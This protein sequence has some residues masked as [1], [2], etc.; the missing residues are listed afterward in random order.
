MSRIRS[1]WNALLGKESIL[2][3]FVATLCLALGLVIVYGSVRTVWEL[4][5]TAQTIP[6]IVRTPPVLWTPTATRVPVSGCSVCP[7]PGYPD[8]APH[9]L[10]DFDMRQDDWHSSVNWTHSGPAVAADGVWWLDSEAEYMLGHKY[11]L[12]TSYGA[13]YDHALANVP[14]LISDLA[15]KVQTGSQGTSVEGMAA[16]LE[17]Y[18]EQQ[19]VSEDYTVHVIKGPSKAWLWDGAWHRDDVVLLLLGFWQQYSGQ[20]TRLGGHWV[21]I[22]CIELDMKRVELV[23]PFFDLAAAGYLGRSWGGVPADATVHNDAANVSYD[24]Y[25]TAGTSV[26][27]AEWTPLH[28][29][30]SRLPEI[31]TNSLGQ[32]FAAD[33][34]AYRGSYRVE[35][36]V[37]VAADYAV[38]IRR[39]DGCPLGMPTATS[40]PTEV[41]TA[42][43]VPTEVPTATT[44][45]TEVPTAT[46]VPTEVP[47]ATSV[48]TEV[49]TATSVP[50][51]VPTAI[52]PIYRLYWPLVFWN[53]E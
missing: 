11:D 32:N 30:Y 4:P 49:P 8:Y 9:G 14:P 6:T 34:E 31:L 25:N 37:A 43:T 12:V 21:G 48:P 38:V 28:Y 15:S 52:P 35:R 51:E 13:W 44:V 47:T 53:R 29:A 23:D 1:I 50:T 46:T 22:C 18:L 7:R 27:G 3:R 5:A 26:P 24:A 42:T 45:P 33:L 36:D 10:P 20:W 17:M 16:G 19:G 2:P 40:V 39:E 41:P